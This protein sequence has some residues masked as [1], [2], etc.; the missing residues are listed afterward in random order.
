M[1]WIKGKDS[2][3][4]ASEEIFGMKSEDLMKKLEAGAEAKA[5]LDELQNTFGTQFN[6]I[7]EALTK[8][9]VTPASSSS[10]SSSNNNGG[11][12]GETKTEEK[13]P[14]WFADPDAAFAH[15]TG[16]AIAPLVQLTLETRASQVFDRVKSSYGDF[17]L[18]EEE[19]LKE[20]QSAPAQYK[21]NEMYVR[22]AYHM[23]KG[24]H[25]DEIAADKAKGSGKYFVEG[26]S[27]NLNRSVVE[28]KD[29]KP[30]LTQEEK[31]YASKFGLTEDAY[32]E[33]KK[34]MKYV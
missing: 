12:N 14:D 29:K 1:P 30:V 22:N 27:S 26:S 28:D 18:F 8:L 5:K 20:M 6:D 33:S 16:K 4:S 25:T 24:R 17:S 11:N 3:K 9:Q 21:A 32:I 23:V 2:D 13:S 34:A 19:I 10:S 7:K 15:H 31:E